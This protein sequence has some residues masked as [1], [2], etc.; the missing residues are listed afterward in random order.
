MGRRALMGMAAVCAGVW[1]GAPDIAHACGGFFCQNTSQPVAQSGEQIAFGIDAD[2]TVTAIIQIDWQGPAEDFA[3]IIPV[4]S[5]PELDTS[6]DALFDALWQSTA[7]TFT[8][9]SRTEGRCRTPRCDTAPGGGGC[10]LAS[11]AASSPRASGGFS[12]D[13]G[14]GASDSGP[15]GPGGVT[16]LAELQAGPY[17]AV[18]L[19][20]VDT[21]AIDAWLTEHAYLFPPEAIAALD[22]YVTDGFKFVVLRLRK[23]APEV[24]DLVPTGTLE[25]VVL[26]YAGG[27]PCIPVRLTAI[28]TVPD[29]PITAFFLAHGDVRPINYLETEVPDE[30]TFWRDASVYWTALSDEVD[31]AG[32]RAFVTEYRG[33]VPAVSISVPEPFE[34]LR[35]LADPRDFF[36]SLLAHGLQGE[37]KLLEVMVRNLPPPPGVDPQEFYDCLGVG[38]GAYAD[39]LATVTFD[40]DAFVDDLEATIRLPRLEAVGLLRRYPRLTRLTTTMSA[41][42]MTIDPEFRVVEP[43]SDISNVRIAELVRVCSPDFVAGQAPIEIRTP[44]GVRAEWSAG[45]PYPGDEEWCG[46][47]GLDPADSGGC[48]IRVPHAGGPLWPL[49]AGLAVAA[50]LLRRRR[51]RP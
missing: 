11:G 35:T 21:P 40:P 50:V 1:L 6:T 48:S 4:T 28:A 29:M 9:V 39:Y 15:G 47:M 13:A 30:T 37:P 3:W 49:G 14:F 18:V 17:E 22:P 42:E 7:V 5:V 25:P 10:V 34:D 27:Q 44:S 16:V 46:R 51:R 41:E 8:T 33:E 23:P 20:G 31:A 36:P 45:T 26:R 19:E 12:A 2:G 38:C 32:G 43:M 24:G